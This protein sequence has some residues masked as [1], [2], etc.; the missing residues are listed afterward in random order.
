MNERRWSDADALDCIADIFTAPTPEDAETG[1]YQWPSG[2]DI[3]EWVH[4]YVAG[5]GRDTH[6]YREGAH[7]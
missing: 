5:T 2:A 4:A 7:P 3:A 1:D 6:S